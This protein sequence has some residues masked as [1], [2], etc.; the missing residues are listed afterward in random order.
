MQTLL[1]LTLLWGYFLSLINMTEIFKFW[2]ATQIKRG[3]YPL[4][5]SLVEARDQVIFICAYK[6]IFSGPPRPAE[7]VTPGWGPADFVR[8][9]PSRCL[10]HAQSLR[11]K[12]LKEDYVFSLFFF[13]G[14]LVL[15]RLQGHCGI[16]NEDANLNSQRRELLLVL[17]KQR[18]Y[19]DKNI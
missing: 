14:A 11:T 12:T 3:F 2:S 13:C 17:S 10:L 18:F 15:Q 5:C 9:K 6:C 1:P 8:T 4:D 19:Q 16:I 7:S